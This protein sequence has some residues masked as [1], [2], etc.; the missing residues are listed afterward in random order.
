MAFARAPAIAGGHGDIRDVV[1]PSGEETN[2]TV[3]REVDFTADRTGNDG[4]DRQVLELGVKPSFL[5]APC[6]S[7]FL[8]ISCLSDKAANVGERS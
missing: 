8:C 3:E 2:N 6:S 4:R 7:V 1:V 5:N